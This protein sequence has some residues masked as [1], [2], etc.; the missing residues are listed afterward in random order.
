MSRHL[1]N[2]VG[3]ASAG[4]TFDRVEITRVAMTHD[5]VRALRANELE[6]CV[7]TARGDDAH[8]MR[9]R[10]LNG[11]DSYAARCAVHEDRFGRP[12]AG[13]LKKR[14][15]RRRVRNAQRGALR[16]RHARGQTM[17]L[18]LRA[19]CPLRVRAGS[20]GFVECGDVHAIADSPLGRAGAD[21]FDLAGAVRSRH[22][23]QLGLD[24]VSAASD[25]RVDGIDAR[26]FDADDNFVR[27]GR[28]IGKLLEAHCLGSAEL[29]NDDG[30]HRWAPG[31]DAIM[32]D[33]QRR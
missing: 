2:Q 3:S 7:R 6:A 24:R 28:R 25:V 19:S 10:D 26:G 30:L 12:R 17:H 4:R 29:V 20:A 5:D 31:P 27:T 15:V 11:R 13:A 1:E 21:R 22:V 33:L 8:A 16:E 9:T 23:R 18:R 14:A 32:R